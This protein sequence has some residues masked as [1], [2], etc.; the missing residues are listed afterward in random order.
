[1][2]STPY[3][4]IIIRYARP[5]GNPL[6]AAEYV[7][8]YKTP[9]PQIYIFSCYEKTKGDPKPEQLVVDLDRLQNKTECLT[10]YR[11]IDDRLYNGKDLII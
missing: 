6:S 1:M 11:Y 4:C 5:T 9:K 7:C 3:M 10:Y 2:D 8:R